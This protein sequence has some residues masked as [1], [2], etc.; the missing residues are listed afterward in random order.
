MKDPKFRII[1]RNKERPSYMESYT[2]TGFGDWH[3]SE[4]RTY[5]SIEEA[6]S[7]AA[8]YNSTWGYSGFEFVVVRTG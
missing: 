2:P 6:K 7:A 8:E 1:F 3:H 5:D 4:Y